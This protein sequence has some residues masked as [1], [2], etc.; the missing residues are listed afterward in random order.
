VRNLLGRIGIAVEMAENGEEALALLDGGGFD[1][2]FMDVRMPV[3]NGYECTQRIR[4]RADALARIPVL[5]VT[6]DA[7]RGDVQ[8]CLAAGMDL[9]LSKPLRLNEVIEAVRALDLVP[10]AA[11]T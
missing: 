8:Q 6:A 9:H 1:L 5:A 3:M 11:A 7:T 2:V 4:A 10:A